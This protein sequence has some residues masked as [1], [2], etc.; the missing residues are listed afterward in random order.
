MN[1]RQISAIM[2]YP[3]L[4]EIRLTLFMVEHEILVIVTYSMLDKLVTLPLPPLL[5]VHT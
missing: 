4:A 1:G 2:T 5:H 3:T